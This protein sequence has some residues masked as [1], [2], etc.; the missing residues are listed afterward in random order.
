MKKKFMSTISALMAGVVILTSAVMIPVKAASGSMSVSGGSGDVGDTITVNV[1]VSSVSGSI[2]SAEG[3]LSYNP[4]ALE[5]VGG[6]NTSGGGGSVG[7]VGVSDSEGNG[8]LSFNVSFRILQ[9]GYH[10]VSGNA[11]VY[12]FDESYYT[13]SNSGTVTGNEEPEPA[14][15]PST[16]SESSSSSSDKEEK[17]EEKEKEEEKSSDSSLSAL[18]VKEGTISP[19]FDSDV[20]NYIVY[21]DE[22]TKEVS[23]EATVNNDKA[24]AD[25]AGDKELKPGANVVTV[26]VTAEDES[27]TEYKINVV[28]GED[29]SILKS[30]EMTIKL[31]S[32]IDDEKVI[33]GFE[34]GTEIINNTEFPVLVRADKKLTLIYGLDS[35]GEERL[36][37]Y[38]KEDG[39]V[40]PYAPI[41]ISEDNVIVPLPLD[42]NEK[43]PEWLKKDYVTIDEVKL[44]AL[45]G[46][47]KDFYYIN[48]LKADG[49]N[50]L[51]KYDSK[52]KTYQRCN[53][54]EL[55]LKNKKDEKIKVFGNIK[56]TEKQMVQ[57]VFVLGVINILLLIGVVC[58]VVEYFLKFKKK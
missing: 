22:A 17:K 1:S 19:A 16:P 23:V 2:G 9:S 12:D 46:E 42:K 20:T 47:E 49:K 40:Y 38:F 5:Y 29:P 51:Y 48:V 24:T 14:T 53:L 8:T 32:E 54:E 7:F 39:S 30:G 36:F 56:L 10:E 6:A 55:A 26:T 33:E 28:C 18:S 50:E 37:I 31:S 57:T 41:T 13:A 15:T 34:R 27:T 3:S 43:Y 52:E 35:K 25:V 21:V 4:S 45:K 58:I 44:E 11:S